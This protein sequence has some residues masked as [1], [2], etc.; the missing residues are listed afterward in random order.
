MIDEEI[1][2]LLGGI[3]IPGNDLHATLTCFH[4]RGGDGIGIIG[5]DRDDIELLR[6]PGFDESGLTGH[7]AGVR[8]I[9]DHIDS[10]FLGRFLDPF[11]ASIEIL[12]TEQLRH[13][14]NLQIL[15]SAR[16]NQQGR[17]QG[18]EE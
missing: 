17:K 3:G 4:E 10:Q 7:I 14:T 1:T 5:S 8:A 6:D 11:L 15:G 9:E 13:H 18:H 2:R 16:Q 12:N